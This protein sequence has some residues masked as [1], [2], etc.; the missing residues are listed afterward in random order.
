VAIVLHH[1]DRVRG[2]RGVQLGPGREPPLLELG[3]LELEPD[4]PFPRGG[5]VRRAPERRLHVGDR[6]CGAQVGVH[7]VVDHAD[8]ME[9]RVDEPRQHAGAVEVDGRELHAARGAKCRATRRLVADGDDPRTGRRD[10]PRACVPGLQR[11]DVAVPVED[12]GCRHRVI[13]TRA[14]TA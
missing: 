11:D 5:R 13:T 1:H 2:A 7:V 9:V 10:R 14:P 8:R 4:D 6:A 3:V 12:G